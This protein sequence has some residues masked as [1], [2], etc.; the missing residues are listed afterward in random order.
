MSDWQK[1]IGLQLRILTNPFMNTHLIGCWIKS[2]YENELDVCIINKQTGSF[3]L[4]LLHD[5][6]KTKQNWDQICFILKIK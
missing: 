3:P 6:K 2:L 1:Y 5:K 4:N